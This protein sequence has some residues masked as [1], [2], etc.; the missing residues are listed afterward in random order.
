[1][2]DLP[3]TIT[4]LTDSRLNITLSEAQLKEVAEQVA[5]ILRRTK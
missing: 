1:M 5:N 2:A 3:L 4:V